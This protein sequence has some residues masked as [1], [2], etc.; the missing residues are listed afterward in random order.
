MRAATGVAQHQF[1][2]GRAAEATLP[3]AGLDR[4]EAPARIGCGKLGIA[5]RTGR[6]HAGGHTAERAMEQMRPPGQQARATGRAD[7][8]RGRVEQRLRTAVVRRVVAQQP[9]NARQPHGPAIHRPPQCLQTRMRR[10]LPPELFTIQ[11]GERVRRQRRIRPWR[12]Q[13]GLRRTALDHLDRWRRLSRQRGQK[14]AEPVLCVV[15]AADGGRGRDQPHL[16]WR[17]AKGGAYAAQQQ[18]HLGRLRAGIG[19]RLVQHD[20]AQR[21]LRCL[22]DR[23]IRRAQQQVFEHRDVGHEDLGRQATDVAAV[24]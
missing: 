11:P 14:V 12:R 3:V 7:G 9:R 1:E 17:H 23:R 13:C 4:A 24:A 15:L 8:T 21:P 18:R 6:V 2:A 22:Q 19:V 5:P 16:P 10:Q 20:P